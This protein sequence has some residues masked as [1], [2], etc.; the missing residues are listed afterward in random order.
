MI[1]DFTTSHF[2]NKKVKIDIVFYL[3][4]ECVFISAFYIILL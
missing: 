3:F 2:T 1:K 4:L